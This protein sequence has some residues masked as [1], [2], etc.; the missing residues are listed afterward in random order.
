[1][2][3]AILTAI[4]FISLTSLI[5]LS[6]ATPVLEVDFT[7]TGPA[8]EL[9]A[10]GRFNGVLPAK[11][12]WEP[13]YPRWNSS[14]VRSEVKTESE[15]KFLRFVVEKVDFAVFFRMAVKD[16]Q[17]PGYYRIEAVFRTENLPLQI[18]LR[19]LP[20]PYNTLGEV[21]FSH[22][23][24]TMKWQ[25]FTAVMELKK[26]CK[27]YIGLYLDLP[28][29]ITDM[30]SL[31]LIKL[32]AEEVEALISR[33]DKT[34]T[35]YFR[36]SRFPLGLPSGWNTG[37]NEFPVQVSSAPDIP[38]PSGSPALKFA[39]L[40]GGSLYTEP[41][42]TGDP[43]T[44]NQVS[45][46]CKGSGEWQVTV[47]PDHGQLVRQNIKLTEQWQTPAIAF[48]PNRMGKNITVKFAGRGTLYLDSL[49]AWSG[50]EL[51]H[52]DH[53]RCEVALAP[54]D[55]EITATRIHF[56]DEPARLRYDV[57]GNYAGAIL[58]SKINN[59]YGQEKVLADIPLTSTNASG[60]IA[61]DVFP[62]MPQ[63]QFR[64]EAWVEKD[65][66][67][68]SPYNELV[69]TRLPRPR[70]WGKDAP[71]S[72]FGCHFYPWGT[73]ITS[74]KAAGIN[75][76]R[77][78][79]AGT[80]YIGWNWLEPVKGQ[81]VFRDREIRAYRQA[82]IKL[83][84]ALESTPTWASFYPGP[85]KSE[86]SYV[87]DKFYQPKDL[88]AFAN[89]VKT[90]VGR[91]QGVIDEY[92]VWNEP[93][94]PCFFAVGYDLN[95]PGNWR[96][97]LASSHAAADY[98]KLTNIAVMAAKATNPAV[99]IIGLNNRSGVEGRQW[100]KNVAAA[101]GLKSCDA[102]DYHSYLNT[103]CGFPDDAVASDYLDATTDISGK[104]VY[105]SEGQGT[106]GGSPE[107]QQE[108]DIGFYHHTIPWKSQE[109]PILLADNTC[110]FVLS[111]LSRPVTRIFL[112]SG[113]C[114]NFLGRTPGHLVLL[115]ADG[116]PHPALAAFS[117]LAWHLEDK[118][119]VKTV[120]IGPNV[121]AY[122]FADQN[123]TCAVI[124]GLRNGS[125]AV[126]A[127]LSAADLFGNPVPSPARYQGTLMYID[128]KT[129]TANAEKLMTEAP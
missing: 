110:R 23:G 13:D 17:I 112:Y 12:G 62:S 67:R 24:Q 87:L 123:G 91:Y 64:L 51:R 95:K 37:R 115:C 44:L 74:M 92:Q 40:E 103:T 27:D 66:Q 47:I 34:V 83:Q 78:H 79:D 56:T 63:G 20:A 89:Y 21:S 76:A 81:W 29:G 69:I 117:A 104:P 9:V 119:F 18:R 8:Q 99:K 1:M 128:F 5:G 2:F 55:G 111:L 101:G 102:I 33:P 86:F 35:N 58:K 32:S 65:G 113:H 28:L 36:N 72:P 77:L 124:S 127:K 42:Q 59:L 73:V 31:K 38:G 97:Y 45:F 6:A 52:Y 3:R 88:D 60:T 7:K 10:K 122:L 48:F 57:T 107:G 85:G 50:K 96:G 49:H 53:D 125:Y 120:A 84:G 82:N 26:P 16:I 121:W 25:Q 43:S 41:F 22:L 68:I 126:P 98:A 105:M 94:S 14:V 129:T 19:Q 71:A 93:W 54:G 100:A 15:R 61:Y 90:V 114:Y 108:E 116:Y 70:Y 109:D 39:A 75:W 80:E 118:K 106:R 46:A 11:G 30:V 4:M